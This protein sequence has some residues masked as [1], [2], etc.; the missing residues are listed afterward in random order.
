MGIEPTFPGLHPGVLSPL[1]YGNPRHMRWISNISTGCG[2]FRR[3]LAAAFS[4][5]RWASGVVGG[6]TPMPGIEPGPLGL[7][8]DGTPSLLWRIIDQLR[9]IYM[10]NLP[11]GFPNGCP[12]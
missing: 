4:V 11:V 3:Q 8:R 10:N 2:L 6:G 12:I 1:N 5:N 7:R 9:P